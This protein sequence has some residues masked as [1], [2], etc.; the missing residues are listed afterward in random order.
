MVT[1]QQLDT[2]IDSLEKAVDDGL[3]YFTGPGAESEQRIGIWEPREVLCHMVYWHQATVE[4][5]ESV[6]SGGEP[7]KIYASTDEMNAR[8]VGRASG[9]TVTVLAQE[10][11]DLQERLLAAVRSMPDTAATVL[12]RGDGR[13]TS[14]T[15][16]LSTIADHW[17]V[18]LAE[19]R[20]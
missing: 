16:R 5:A 14:A 11:R 8:A 3:A 20:G 17:N 9:K 18:H 4:G 6:A 2:L 10:V 12:I 7:H 15:G 13:E 19:L 1:G